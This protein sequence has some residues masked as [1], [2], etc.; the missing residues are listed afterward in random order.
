[1]GHESD[2]SNCLKLCCHGTK[3]TTWCRDM[4]VVES[5][6]VDSA[7]PIGKEVGLGQGG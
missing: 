5:G 2:N 6:S 1:M 7:I 4:C 3:W